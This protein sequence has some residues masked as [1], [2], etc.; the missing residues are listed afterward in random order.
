VAK[1]KKNTVKISRT[2]KPAK[3]TKSKLKRSDVRKAKG[4][5]TT[6]ATAP[7]LMTHAVITKRAHE[8][9]LKKNHAHHTN[10]ALQ[11]WMEAEAQLRAEG[12]K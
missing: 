2:K 10:H 1:K 11:N 8:I 3:K 4:G 9:W 6:V 5:T 12:Y 7:L